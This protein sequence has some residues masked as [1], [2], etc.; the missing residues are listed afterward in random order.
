M[1]EMMMLLLLSLLLLSILML[2]CVCGCVRVRVC[3]RARVCVLK[4]RGCCSAPKPIILSGSSSI[5]PSL[6]ASRTSSLLAL[7]AY[8]LF[9]LADL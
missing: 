3:A 8:A 7:T 5:P 9:R 6:T 4:L 2:V 1:M